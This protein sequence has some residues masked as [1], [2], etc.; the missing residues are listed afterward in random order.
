MCG[1]VKEVKVA[2]ASSFTGTFHCRQQ[3]AE[4]MR[5]VCVGRWEGGEGGGEEPREQGE[6]RKMLTMVVL[7]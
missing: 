5:K 4:T 3:D 6:E 1:R 2:V 7:V